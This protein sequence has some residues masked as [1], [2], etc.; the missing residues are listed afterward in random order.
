[1]SKPEGGFI[2]GSPTVW[3]DPITSN[4]GS[5]GV[6]INPVCWREFATAKERDE[7]KWAEHPAYCA[8]V[9]GFT[10]PNESTSATRGRPAIIPPEEMDAFVRDAPSLAPD[11]RPNIYP[12]KCRT[13][14]ELLKAGEGCL[15]PDPETGK[16][17]VEHVQCPAVNSRVGEP[18]GRVEW[19][20]AIVV[21]CFIMACM[22][23]RG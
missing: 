3:P 10:D 6:K 8:E 20:V 2:C 16:M 1:M 4:P 9:T 13:C 15:R 5:K 18:L 11:T 17:R 19:T 14:G 21:F 22:A 12:G 7:H 23:F